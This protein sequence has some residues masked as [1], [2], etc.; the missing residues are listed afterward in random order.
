MVASVSDLH[1]RLAER[2][3]TQI[4]SDGSATAVV[5]HGSVAHGTHRSTSDIDL[6]VIGSTSTGLQRLD[7]DGLCV[8]LV[9]R[10]SDGW[11]ATFA[12]PAPAWTYAWSEGVVLE[13]VDHAAESMIEAA[14]DVLRTFKARSSLLV[15]HLEFWA[16]V[17]PKLAAAVARGDTCEIGYAMSLSM[18]HLVESLFLV[19][20][21]VPSPTSSDRTFPRLM[22]LHS[23]PGLEARLER[24]LTGADVTVRAMEK[25]DLIDLLW[26]AMRTRVDHNPD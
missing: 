2:V 24:I 12:R 11:H 21:V 4:M 20:D 23:P 6:M 16:H 22:S 9:T 26:D 15:E 10:T 25:L 14:S 1:Y 8:E 17:R 3:A 18:G 5:L 13:Q 7:V 19:N